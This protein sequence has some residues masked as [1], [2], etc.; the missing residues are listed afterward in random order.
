MI[1]LLTI[2][3]LLCLPACAWLEGEQM[4]QAAL[5]Q[6]QNRT[7]DA[8]FAQVY[9]AAL[10]TMFDLGYTIS[11]TDKES[12]VVVGEKARKRAW[13]IFDTPPEHQ[14]KEDLYDTLQVT[15]MVTPIGKKQTRVRIK[16]ALN[17]ESQLDKT[18]INEI[19]LHIERQVLMHDEG[20][21]QKAKG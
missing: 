20:P 5:A 8:P 7:I 2:C 15:L 13:S 21:A 18:A 16:T 1:R 12:G 3:A 10:E 6:L 17:K 19:W 9:P 14:H 4:G 11:H